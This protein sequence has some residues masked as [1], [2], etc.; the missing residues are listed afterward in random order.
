MIK[1]IC[2]EFKKYFFKIFS[3]KI[4]VSDIFTNHF[5]TLYDYR[6][7][8]ISNKDIGTFVIFPCL[9]SFIFVLMG[10][11]LTDKSLDIISLSLS[12]FTPILFSLVIMIFSID[13][14]DIKNKRYYLIIRELTSNILFIIIISLIILVCIWIHY[15]IKEL[16]VL[17]LGLF[18]FTILFL[19]LI[20]IFTLLMIL[21]RL[22]KL[23]SRKLDKL[24]PDS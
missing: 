22:N 10:G 7:N 6:N 18:S 20:L 24:K 23:L 1:R 4:D 15:S 14:K 11:R 5:L 17:N 21:K 9:V 16:L 12:I 19:L 8:K 2:E 13:E 3:K